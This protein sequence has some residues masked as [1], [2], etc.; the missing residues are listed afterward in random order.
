[1]KD[2]TMSAQR[3]AMTFA[4]LFVLVSLGLAHVGGQINLGNISWLWVTLFVGANLTF[5]GVTGFCMMTKIMKAA[6]AR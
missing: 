6:G 5:A 1:M 3:L 4:G 2:K